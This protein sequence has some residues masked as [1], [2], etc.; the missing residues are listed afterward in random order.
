MGALPP[1]SFDSFF[2][3]LHSYLQRSGVDGVKVDAQSGL[4]PFAS[5]FATGA[6][7]YVR[8]AVHAMER[9][10]VTHFRESTGAVEVINC[11]C[12]SSEN[13]LAYTTGP[14]IRAAD[15]YYPNDAASLQTHL[16]H[17]SFNSVFL[18][19]IGHVDW[20][21]FEST[22]PAAHV[23]AAA[24]AVGGC[25]V[26]VSDKPGEHNAELLKK[27]CLPDGRVLRAEQPGRPTEDCLMCDVGS[28]GRTALKIF[29]TNRFTGVVACFNVQGSEWS[30]RLRRYVKL[31]EAP[32]VLAAVAPAD[33]SS[34][35]FARDPDGRFAVYTF[36][37]GRVHVAT[38]F[39]RL[40]PLVLS[41]GDFEVFTVS[42]IK[43]AGRVS[44][45]PL[46]LTSHLNG[47][48]AILSIWDDGPGFSV[49]RGGRCTIFA[50]E[51]PVDVEVDGEAVDFTYENHTVHLALEPLHESAVGTASVSLTFQSPA[52]AKAAS[53]SVERS[54]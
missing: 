23:H 18:G 12:H 20:D 26:Y 11:M 3:G 47:G 38:S 19:E 8:Q 30:R 42:P 51:R 15:D 31:P 39:Q 27:M 17:A 24:R 53:T 36:L 41:E 13:L 33:V 10:A 1:A 9:S 21:M 48:A 5:G 28:D 46:G 22:H 2:E 32:P 4:G 35:A 50:D 25:A 14:V 52:Q 34:T 44:W 54:A 7:G 29:S 45:A 40:P 37:E 43:R 16:T 49:L 6:A